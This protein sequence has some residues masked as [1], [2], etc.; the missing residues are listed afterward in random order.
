M[1]MTYFALGVSEAHEA[2]KGARARFGIRAQASR[3]WHDVGGEP[4]MLQLISA[5]PQV[6]NLY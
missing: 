2:Q 4:R 1:G 5:R 3:T 6:D